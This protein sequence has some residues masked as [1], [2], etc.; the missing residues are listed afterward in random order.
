[1]YHID[2]VFVYI[3]MP[4]CFEGTSCVVMYGGLYLCTFRL[5]TYIWG[6]MREEKSKSGG[7]RRGIT[8]EAGIVG[9]FVFS[10]LMSLLL[11]HILTSLLVR[12]PA[13]NSSVLKGRG[14]G[15][16]LGG[17][18]WK[19]CEGRERVGLVVTLLTKRRECVF[20]ATKMHKVPIIRD[21]L[22]GYDTLSLQASPVQIT[23]SLHYCAMSW[24]RPLRSVR[25][26][27]LSE[28]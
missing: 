21:A 9:G 2:G 1:L 14:G 27:L 26:G 20:D 18:S 12:G 8:A 28:I 17:R 22:L 4:V 25:G 16:W 13:L 10:F 5:H 6:R 23:G 3:S 11:M 24:Y 19:K 15:V 7:R